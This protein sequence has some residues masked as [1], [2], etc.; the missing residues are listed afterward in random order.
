M[1][2]IEIAAACYILKLFIDAGWTILDNHTRYKRGMERAK[3][4]RATPSTG[5]K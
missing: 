1:W 5:P 2:I 3:E 4:L